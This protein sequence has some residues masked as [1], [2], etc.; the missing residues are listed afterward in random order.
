MPLIPLTIPPGIFRNGTALQGAGRWRDCNL[1]RWRDGIMRPVGG[2]EERVSVATD[3]VR[4][5]IAWADNDGDQRFAAGTATKLWTVSASN[6][7]TDITPAGITT[8]LE[9]ATVETG[10]GYG[11]YGAGYYGTPRPDTGNYSEADTWSLDTWG[12]FLVGCLTSDGKIYEWQLNVANDAAVVTN[13]PTGCL[14][15]V[16]TDERFLFALGAGG[17]VR[18]VQWCD[19]ENNT[20]W[21]PSATN[22][23]GDIEL[24][25]NGQIMCGL[26]TRGQTLILTDVDAHVAT[27]QGPPFVYGFQRVGTSCGSISRKAAVNVDQGAFWMGQRGF[28]VYQG[29]T[30]TEIPSEVGD[31]VFDNI[32]SA[33]QSKIVALSNAQNGEIWWFYPSEGSTENDAYVAYSY[34]ENHWT[35]GSLERTGGF[36]RGVF[37]TPIWFDSAGMSFNHE[38]GFNHD[39]ASV[40]AESAPVQLGNGDQWMVVTDMIPDEATQGDVEAT[41][42]TKDYPNG[43]ELTFGPYDMANPTSVRFQGRQI[44]VRFDQTRNSEWRVGAMRFDARP[45][46]RR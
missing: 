44:V 33:Q 21:T 41:F 34:R 38:V 14:G 40:Y 30:V 12:E 46:S 13:A 23:A 17:N 32:N 31:Y 43:T 25:T 27:Y 29:D 35:I 22:E 2:W 1:V 37:R 6:T 3:S 20:S 39:G 45:G 18:K 16:V 9:D 42:K 26:R 7:V 8:G 24:Q 15:L 36:D 19:R 11:F 28:F 10:Y 5:A 4:A